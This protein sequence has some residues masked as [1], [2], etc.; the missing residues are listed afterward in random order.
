[1]SFFGMLLS[2]FHLYFRE[3]SL[4]ILDLHWIAIFVL[5]LLITVILYL[6]KMYSLSGCISLGITILMICVLLDVSIGIRLNGI[7]LSHSGLNIGSE[8]HRFL[9]GGDRYFVLALF[10]LVGFVPFGFFLS[11]FLSEMKRYRVK[12]QLENVSFVAFCISLFIESL[13]YALHVGYFEL[14]D[15][16]LNTLGALVGASVALMA[17]AFVMNVI[18]KN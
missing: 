4:L 18:K 2:L 8:Y 11:E 5:S 13:Q 9:R 17:R 12:R 6:R 3:Y 7:R 1:M 16:I 14:T 15:L 10:N